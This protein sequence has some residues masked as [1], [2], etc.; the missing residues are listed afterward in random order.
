MDIQLGIV[1][2]EPMKLAINLAEQG[3]YTVSPNPMVGAVLLKDGRLIG[4]G[5][6]LFQGDNHAEIKAIE[7]ASLNV[8]GATYISI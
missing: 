1:I 4:Y 8:Q 6:H 2:K 5:Y 7:M 3:K